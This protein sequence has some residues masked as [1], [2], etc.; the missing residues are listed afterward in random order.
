MQLYHILNGD[1]LAEQLAEAMLNENHIVFRECLIEGPFLGD[2]LLDF[3]E[4][5]A[6][7]FSERY[8]V[9]NAEFWARTVSEFEKISEIP[10]GSEVCLWFE[11][12]LFCQA[13]LWFL[14]SNLAERKDLKIYRVFPQIKIAAGKWKGFGVSTKED[15]MLAFGSKNP[16]ISY[17]RTSGYAPS[18]L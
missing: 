12:D 13:N 17:N 2:T 18:G 6:K 3:W 15:L 9:T 1:C 4:N 5:R 11:N 7:F 10:A 14:N 16:F 8:K